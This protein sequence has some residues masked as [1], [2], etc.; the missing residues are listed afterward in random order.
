MKKKS[1]A[2]ACFHEIKKD[3][4]TFFKAEI[5][6]MKLSKNFTSLFQSNGRGKYI[7]K[8]FQSEL[9]KAGI[10]HLTIAPDTPK[11]NRLAKCMNQTLVNTSTAMFIESGLPK[12]FWSDAM[13][14][15]CTPTT[16]LK[17]KVPYTVMFGHKVDIS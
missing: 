16:G 2:P 11:Q 5:G 4:E 7:G 12:L 15:S 6:K 17:G 13:V 9:S 1:K 10:V 3:V 8:Q 14:I